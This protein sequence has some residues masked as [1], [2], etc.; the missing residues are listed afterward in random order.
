MAEYNALLIGLEVAKKV[1]AMNLEAYGYS[2]LIVIQVRGEYEVRHEDL[3]PYYEA[4]SRM[5]KEFNNFYMGHLP[6]QQN[7][8]AYAL[9]FLAA[10]L[11]LSAGA[12]KKVLVFTHDLFCPN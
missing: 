3:I 5:A 1:G 4:V 7:A 8:H 9:A 2:M 10:S 11:A 6:H 12:S